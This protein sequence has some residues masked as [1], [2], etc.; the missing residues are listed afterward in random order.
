[1]YQILVIEDHKEISDIVKLYIEDENR[2]VIL[3]YDGEEGLTQF[4]NNKVDLIIVDIML[5]KKDGYSVIKEVRKTSNIPIIVLSSKNDDTDKILGL[6]V[7]A[8][9]YLEKPFN[10]LELSA[11][12]NAQLRRFYKLGSDTPTNTTISFKGFVLDLEEFRVEKDNQEILLTTIEYKILKLLI[13]HP[14]RVYTKSQ[15]YESVLGEFFESDD[16]T[17]MVHISNLRSKIEENPRK[18][19]YIINLRGL[20][21]KFEK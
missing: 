7:G 5:P 6:N 14:G 13:S 8:D 15:I 9:D 12:V 10:G 4:Y 1:M 21:Y 18:P 20:G 16:N 11:R 17:I 2:E 3:A 19:Q